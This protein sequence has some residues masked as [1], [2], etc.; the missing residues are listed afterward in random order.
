M[1]TL[2][3]IIF[4]VL[5]GFLA[6]AC[7]SD[8]EQTAIVEP[9]EQTAVKFELDASALKYSITDSK[10]KFSPSYTKDGF[11]VYAFRQV[12]GSSDYLFEKVINHANMTY[13]AS[14]KKLV[15]TDLLTIGTYKF[16]C[17]YGVEQT[18]VV[19]LP[20]WAG[21]VLTNDFI[22]QYNGTAA[23]GEIF[24]EDTDVNTL[25]SYPL[26]LT[27]ATNPTVTATLK[28]AVSRIDVMFFKGKKE[29]NSYTELPYTNGNNVFGMKTLETLQL[30]YKDLNSTIDFFGNYVSA[31]VLS[32]V[33]VN[34]ANFNNIVTIGT[35]GATTVGNDD[36]T[37]YDNV[38]EGD[39]IKGAAHVFGN[40]V[41]PNEDD[42]KTASLEIYIKPMAGEGRTITLAEKLPMEQNK[43]T[44]VKIYVIDNGGDEPDVFTTNVRFEVEIETVWDG[45]NEVTG[46]IN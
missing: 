32:N 4:L 15:G 11:R 5:T 34:L 44:L 30:R 29:G 14:D 46:E 19:T 20:T 26:G 40:Y 28:R 2:R 17:A 37:K 23:L 36:Y 12:P 16:L 10:L 13:S 41:I 24:L 1:K 31:P 43:V 27:S 18:G 25:T 35:A 3:I 33:N 39:M 8:D 6:T 9:G 21:K 42:A 7:Q 22:M 45:S 38:E